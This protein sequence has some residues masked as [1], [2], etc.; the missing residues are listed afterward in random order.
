[1][2]QGL[3]KNLRSLSLL[4]G[5]MGAVPGFSQ[6]SKEI[7]IDEQ[8]NDFHAR[9]TVR[10]GVGSEHYEIL[11]IRSEANAIRVY[12]VTGGARSLTAISQQLQLQIDQSMALSSELQLKIL[13]DES[14][15]AFW[16]KTYPVDAKNAA[17]LAK[18]L[19]R[20]YG[21]EN[22]SVQ[23]PGLSQIEM[24][25]QMLKFF[26]HA[27][28]PKRLKMEVGRTEDGTLAAVVRI[29]IEHNGE[30]SQFRVISEPPLG[31]DHEL[32]KLLS[33]K[34]LHYRRRNAAFF[35]VAS[36]RSEWDTLVNLTPNEQQENR[37]INPLTITRFNPAAGRD[38]Q[39]PVTV[40]KTFPKDK[41]W[42]AFH[43]KSDPKSTWSFRLEYGSLKH[44]PDPQID[45]LVQSAENLQLPNWFEVG[46]KI[47]SMPLKIRSGSAWF[48]RV[49]SFEEHLVDGNK[50]YFFKTVGDPGP[51]SLSGLQKAFELFLANPKLVEDMVAG[52]NITAPVGSTFKSTMSAS[53]NF[54]AYAFSPQAQHWIHFRPTGVILTQ[55]EGTHYMRVMADG[56]LYFRSPWILETCESFVSKPVK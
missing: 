26:S 36:G 49:F 52:K 5:F 19:P 41:E 43:P 18:I 29:E 37:V 47:H 46:T 55:S 35:A 31:M 32:F 10:F 44:W 2:I 3:Q 13:R 54:V 34:A 27:K 48:R 25:I 20:N 9:A 7:P 4:I 22:F 39:V 42:V 17:N 50:L 14:I 1:M 16:P 21:N 51:V 30:K 45:S 23:Q 28:D 24:N 38:E 8:L 12:S 56:E 11:E 40:Q 6:T 53:A 33:E 15:L